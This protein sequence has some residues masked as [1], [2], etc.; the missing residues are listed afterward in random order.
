MDFAKRL[1]VV[2]KHLG[3]NKN[4]FAV[5]LG[6][7]NNTPIYDYT[8]AKD[9]KQ[10]GFDFFR[11]FI[12]AKTGINI[13]W[14]FTGEGEMKESAGPSDTAERAIQ[15]LYNDLRHLRKTNGELS[16]AVLNFSRAQN[17]VNQG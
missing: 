3:Y 8:R 16:E 13:Q 1:T 12:Q 4:S 7:E 14:L 11:R 5:L 15:E 2:I 10:P 6:Y 9:P 17:R